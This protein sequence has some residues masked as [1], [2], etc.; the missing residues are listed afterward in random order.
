MER[1]Y[2]LL[3]RR[4][5]SRPEPRRE[6]VLERSLGFARSWRCGR[7]SGCAQV[8]TLELELHA[9]GRLVRLLDSTPELRMR[10]GAT[11]VRCRAAHRAGDDAARA[12]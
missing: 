2:L 4:S 12:C 3:E 6:V 8:L 10:R 5:E 7:R 9:A 11:T 1:D